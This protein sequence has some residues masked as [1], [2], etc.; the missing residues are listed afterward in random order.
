MATNHAAAAAP[1]TAYV[2]LSEA[3]NQRAVDRIETAERESPFCLCGASMIA[4]A[5]DG[6]IWLQCSDQTR[7]KRRGIGGFVARISGSFGH[8]R[9]IIMEL[10]TVERAA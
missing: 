6:S 2:R 10:P 7:N 4:V 1:A 5:H 8:S 3:E 9:R